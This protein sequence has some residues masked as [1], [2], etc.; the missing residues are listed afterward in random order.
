[1][2]YGPSYQLLILRLC[3]P[4]KTKFGSIS[5][6]FYIY[7]S[8]R[9][10]TLERQEGREKERNI[11][12]RNIDWLPPICSPPGNSTHDIGMCLDQELNLKPFG[13]WDHAPTNW[14]TMAGASIS[15]FYFL[16]EYFKDWIFFH[17]FLTFWSNLPVKP[18]GPG[19]FFV[20]NFKPQIKFFPNY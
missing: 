3:Y 7:F 4:N 15:F 8:V 17:F 13:V 10:L 14:A 9:L 16:Q 18:C 20:G 5:F 12:V 1:M 6:F 2:S 19:V 11:D